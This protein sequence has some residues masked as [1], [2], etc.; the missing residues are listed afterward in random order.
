MIGM[1]NVEFALPFAYLPSVLRILKSE[2]LTSG[3]P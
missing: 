1:W 3:I 2:R